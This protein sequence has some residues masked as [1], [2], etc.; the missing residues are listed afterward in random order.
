MSD[1]PILEVHGNGL[2]LIRQVVVI[3]KY[4]G[5]YGTAIQNR[6][7]KGEQDRVDEGAL[8]RLGRHGVVNIR[9]S[10]LLGSN[11]QHPNARQ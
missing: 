2:D 6:G 10:L 7:P 5:N 11:C 3:E 8:S 4:I 9:Y 1:S